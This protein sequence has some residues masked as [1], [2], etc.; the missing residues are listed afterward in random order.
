MSAAVSQLEPPG[1]ARPFSMT[2]EFVTPE[3]TEP[4]ETAIKPA[5]DLAARFHQDRRLTGLSVTDRVRSEHDHDPSAVARRIFEVSGQQPIVHLAGKNREVDD[6]VRS[7]EWMQ[8]HDLTRALII[9][10]DRVKSEPPGG[11]TRYL[12][13]VPAIWTAKQR[14]PTLTVAAAICPFK[15]REE[16]CLSQYLKLGKKIRAGADYLITQIGYDMWKFQELIWWCVRRGY[17]APLVANLMPLTAPRGRYIRT[18]RIPGITITDSLQELLEEEARE[19]DKGRRRAFRRLALQIIGVKRLGYA[20]VQFTAIHKWDGLEEVLRLVDDL[21]GELALRGDW[22][23]AWVDALTF[24]DRRVAQV[25]PPDGFDLFEIARDHLPD[26]DLKA[27]PA[28]R[29]LE[30]EALS[31]E[32]R[33]YRMLDMLDHWVFQQ[34][35]PGARVLASMLRRVPEGSLLDEILSRLEKA[36]KE[37]IVGCQACGSCRLPHTF[38][39]CP[40]TCPKGLANGPCGGTTDNQCEFGD[41]ECIHNLKYRIAREAGAL[42]DLEEVLIPAVPIER[43]GSCSWTAHFKGQGPQAVRVEFRSKS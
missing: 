17:E 5:L 13:S 41:R 29:P 35:S 22:W 36:T 32:I 14:W 43:R 40:E 26:A 2:V 4:F 37:R 42:R 24:K 20:G 23:L 8:A 7:L 25:A 19:P 11:R 3:D 10:G 39:V 12:E 33:K 18:N 1:R 38:Y 15:Y 16:E 31:Q 28:A 9:T 27:A 21:E 34:G 30:A 6:L